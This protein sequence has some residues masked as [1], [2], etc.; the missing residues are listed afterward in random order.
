MNG[1]K[2][3]NSYTG[4]LA[5]LLSAALFVFPLTG[6]SNDN[7][8]ETE[9]EDSSNV[10]DIFKETNENTDSSSQDDDNSQV[11]LIKSNS[12]DGN[13][14]SKDS[15]DDEDND[16]LIK[17]N[18][19]NVTLEDMYMSEI[20][21]TDDTVQDPSEGNIFVIAELKLENTTQELVEFWP[22]VS[23]I[24]SVD[25]QIL[26]LSDF[27]NHYPDFIN[28]KT[29]L[30]NHSETNISAGGSIT[31]C[32]VFEI[33]KSFI[34][35][36]IA[37]SD[38]RTVLGAFSFENKSAEGDSAYEKPAEVIKEADTDSLKIS[39]LNV[40]DIN[41]ESYELKQPAEGCKYINVSL[42][43][44][45][46]TDIIQMI[47]M[48]NF[49]LLA[50]DK[51]IEPFIARRNNDHLIPEKF[52]LGGVL[53]EVPENAETLKLLYSPGGIANSGVELFDIND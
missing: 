39:L 29:N 27:I 5:I 36:E 47:T 17:A 6:C 2:K 46:K 45:N 15:K 37:Y 7:N 44:E 24:P 25:D 11:S 1:S 41:L 14:E 22:S 32:V 51:T 34:K 30:L 49:Y 38:G 33:D 40:S 16:N 42:M 12:N 35:G 19:L 43:L 10:S 13:N 23:L 26:T 52:F 8:D 3:H 50:D 48:N 21:I 31:G 28:G 18:E 20:I 53:F 9:K 4:L